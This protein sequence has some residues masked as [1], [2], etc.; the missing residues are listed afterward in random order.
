MK[1]IIISILSSGINDPTLLAVIG[2]M[3]M[4]GEVV[5][6]EGRVDGQC[7]NVVTLHFT[8]RVTLEM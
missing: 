1:N 4:I 7:K 3:T 6:K 2:R 5:G 8:R